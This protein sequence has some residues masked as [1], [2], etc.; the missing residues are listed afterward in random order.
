MNPISAPDIVG[1]KATPCD[2]VSRNTSGVPK[3]PCSTVVSSRS[4]DVDAGVD[5]APIEGH[6]LTRWRGI[7]V[8]LRGPVSEV[9]A[10]VQAG[11]VGYIFACRCD[12]SEQEISYFPDFYSVNSASNSP[13]DDAIMQEIIPDVEPDVEQHLRIIRNAFMRSAAIHDSRARFPHTTMQRV[14]NVAAIKR[15]APSG[16]SVRG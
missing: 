14:K 11:E 12:Y 4:P 5:G 10:T 9:D 15:E 2:A 16:E 3:S 7:R 1:H 13:Y 8:D 6:P